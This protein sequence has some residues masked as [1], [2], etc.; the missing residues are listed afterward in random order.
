MILIDYVE[1]QALYADD[2]TLMIQGDDIS[3]ADV[4]R[5]SGGKV[6][7]ASKAQ[8]QEIMEHSEEPALLKI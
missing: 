7:R 1:W 6:M 4:V 3:V 2:G 5:L 8:E